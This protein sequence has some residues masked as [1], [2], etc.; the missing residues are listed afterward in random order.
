MDGQQ[1]DL[2]K[3]KVYPNKLADD[4]RG[5]LRKLYI[6]SGDEQLLVQETTDLIRRALR[7]YGFMERELF[8][9]EAGFEWSS[10][11]QSVASMS[12]FAEKKLIEVRMP[13]GKPGDKGGK[14]LAELTDQLNEDNVLLLALP[15]VGQ[16]VQRS[17][18]FKTLFAEGAFTQIWPIEAKN[19]PS[20]LTNRFRQAGLRVTNDAVTLMADRVEGNLLAAVQEI[21]RLRLIA[22]NGLVDVREVTDGVTDSA[23]FDVFQLIDAAMS[24]DAVKIVRMINGL[25]QRASKSCLFSS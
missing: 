21:E 4:L 3:V 16:D 8:H 5:K 6:V 11:L 9:A 2:R 1:K 24:G 17:R 15:K 18:W 12:L 10:L 13:S 7:S 22:L 23:R 20:W 19:L 14:I 25:R